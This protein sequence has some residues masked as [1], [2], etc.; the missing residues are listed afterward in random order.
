MEQTSFCIHQPGWPD[1]PGKCL[2]DGTGGHPE[3]MQQHS[4]SF[5][6]FGPSFEMLSI[7]L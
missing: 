4:P 1:I 5:Q 3:H 2:A 7:L 6:L